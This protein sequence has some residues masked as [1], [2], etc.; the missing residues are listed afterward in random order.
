MTV[1]VL[2]A[3]GMLG[4]KVFQSLGAS[5]HDVIGT[6]RDDRAASPLARIPL[7]AGTNV[8]WN[9]DAMN[10]P[11]LEEVLTL[12]RPGVIVNAAGVIKQRPQPQMTRRSIQVNSL[13]PHLVAET[14]EAWHGRLIHISSDCVFSG[15]RGQ[16]RES[17]TQDADDVYGKSKSLGE[18]ID[19]ANA[20]TLRTS[21]IGRELQHHRSLLDWLLSQDHGRVQGYTRVIYS[22]STTIELS[23]VIDRVIRE[24]PSLHGLYHVV[25]EPI[26]KDALLRLLIDAYGIDIH[27]TSVDTPVSDRS[28][29]GERFFRATGYVAPPWPELVRALASDP[30]PYSDWFSQMANP[31]AS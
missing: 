24:H 11:R 8:V 23:K 20:V 4:H 13:M 30:T 1:L 15:H 18:V 10:W 14:I 25:T 9:V 3:S 26:S 7:F 28:L 19:R 17:D 29:I 2:G 22:G 6:M 27:V 5:G 16:Y 31:S 12:V 21:I